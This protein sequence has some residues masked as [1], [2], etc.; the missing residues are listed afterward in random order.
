MAPGTS[1]ASLGM[2]EPV[3]CLGRRT[4]EELHSTVSQPYHR[5]HGRPSRGCGCNVPHFGERYR[6]TNVEDVGSLQDTDTQ[7]TFDQVM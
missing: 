3:P 5:Q 7:T 4:Y 1:R 2:T 6:D